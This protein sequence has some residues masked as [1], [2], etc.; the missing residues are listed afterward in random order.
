MND[1]ADAGALGLGDDVARA[2][3]VDALE[4][5]VGRRLVN[6]RDEVHDDVAAIRGASDRGGVGDITFDS[7]D[8]A[9]PRSRV[10]L[11][12][13]R[14]ETN[15]VAAL[16]QSGNGRCADDTRTARDQNL[17]CLSSTKP[18]YAAARMC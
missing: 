13:P 15:R 5:D 17:H 1:L 12:V 7:H 6:D 9:W 11:G 16:E 8:T 2:V 14:Q 10:A 4:R 18:A 3:D